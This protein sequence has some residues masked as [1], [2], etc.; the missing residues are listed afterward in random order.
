MQIY[1][2]GATRPTNPGPG[3]YG[4]FI[5]RGD[6]P[7]VELAGYLG[8]SVTSNQCEYVALIA[9]LEWLQVNSPAG[10]GEAPVY[11]DS[12]LVVQQVTGKWAM[13]SPKLRPLWQRARRLLAELTASG[14]EVRLAHVAGHAGVAGNEAADQLAGEAVDLQAP[15]PA[16][17]RRLVEVSE[18]E[19][20]ALRGHQMLGRAVRQDL[21]Q[22]GHCTVTY[23]GVVDPQ[24]RRALHQH[25]GE[26]ALRLLRGPNLLTVLPSGPLALATLT[27]FTKGPGG[28]VLRAVTEDMWGALSALALGGQPV[29]VVHAPYSKGKWLTEWGEAA[30]LSPVVAL[31]RR[32]AVEP[33]EAPAGWFPTLAMRAEWTPWAEW[34]AA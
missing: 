33:V 20:V 8:A 10:V 17:Y 27:S 12:L 11:S 15:A 31:A 21:L 34:L 13:Y 29:L 2:D 9:A 16:E 28:R 1:T 22:Q 30:E 24:M 4:V 5:E 25:G 7:P 26:Q 14:W 23:P 32:I 3:G 18:Q 19:A 6:Q